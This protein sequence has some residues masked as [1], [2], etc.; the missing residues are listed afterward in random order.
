MITKLSEPIFKVISAVADEEG[1]DA[2]VIGGYV[3]DGILKRPTKDIDVMVVG[4]GIAFAKKVAGKLGEDVD[5]AIYKNFGTAMVKFKGQK[6]EFVGARKE[7]YKEDSR[8]PFV[9]NGTLE[10][11]QNR[12]D[13]TINALAVG[14]NK[15]NYGKLLDPFDGIA[16]LQRKI[17]RTPMDPGVTFSDDPLRM[18]RAIRFA[19]QLKFQIEDKTYNSLGE[20]KERIKIVSKERI[21][22]EL[23]KIILSPKPSMGFKMLYNVGLLH[24]IFPELVDLSGVE[25][26]KGRSHKDNFLHTLQV[27]DNI[28]ETSD[29]LWLR[30]AALLHD[31]AKPSTKRFNNKAGWTFHGHEF[32]GAKM[33]PGIFR[34]MRL[35]LNEK[36]KF[37][38]KMVLLHLRPIALVKDVVSDSGVRRLLFDAGDDIDDLMKLCEADITSK[39]DVKVRQFLHNFNIV[40]KKLKDVEKKDK[41]RNWQPPISGKM[42]MEAFNIKE[43]KEVG[44]IKTKIREAILNGDIGNEK[45]EAMKFM[46]IVGKELGLE[47]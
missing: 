1:I 31:V 32:K 47:I 42:I 16:D 3:R 44:I 22:D 36:M 18:L 2:Y 10:D 24:I 14:L 43:G 30:W 20:N 15:I 27:L 7:S 12:R 9:E 34:S 21:T 11:D 46:L 37:V 45:E 39:N 29:S 38:Q 17:I 35:P 26:R 33:V 6:V 19:S 8:K 23:N 5:L 41:L 25:K 40:R 28:C 13:F 4:S